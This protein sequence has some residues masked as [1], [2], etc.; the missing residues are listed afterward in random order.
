MKKVLTLFTAAALTA[1]MSMAAFAEDG[2]EPL[3]CGPV[4]PRKTEKPNYAI[5]KLYLDEDGEIP[6]CIPRE[7][8]QFR[9]TALEGNP[10]DTMISIA[11]HEV[12][13]NPDHIAIDVPKYT[14]VGRYNYQVQEL[15]GNTQGVEYAAEPLNVQILAQW[16]EDHSAI[17]TTMSFTTASGEKKV[18]TFLNHYDLGE[19]DIEK[20]VTGNL[21]DYDKEF[22]V[23]VTFTAE[24]GKTVRSDI[25]YEMDGNFYTIPASAMADGTET[26]TV[27]LKHD[28]TVSFDHLPVGIYYQVTE[29][30]YTAGGTNSE[31]G[32]DAPV[33]E[34]DDDE[35][36]ITDQGVQ[37]RITADNDD[38]DVDI[39]N[40]KGTVVETGVFLDS[41]PYLILMGI[42]AVSGVLLLKKRRAV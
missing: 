19:L 33:Y 41:V 26:V 18:D 15:S 25:S 13:E 30:D 20:E 34:V 2:T 5:G 7:Q 3:K 39:I 40:N 11:P 23:D 10:D 38:V 4:P 9:V 14:K 29:Q 24:E 1:S 27:S 31:N 17:V 28:E 42:V 37:G 6:D 21:G 36:Q 22:L 32:Y 16:N 35:G 8:L 12:K